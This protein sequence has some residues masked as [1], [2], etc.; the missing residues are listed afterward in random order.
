MIT[1][2]DLMISFLNQALTATQNDPG[3]EHVKKQQQ[4]ICERLLTQFL[5]ANPEEQL[6]MLENLEDDLT[7]LQQRLAIAFENVKQAKTKLDNRE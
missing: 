7:G 2:N 5:N 6:A 1:S 3:Q 4:F